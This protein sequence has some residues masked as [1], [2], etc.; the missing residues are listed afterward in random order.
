V[1][2]ARSYFEKAAQ[3]DSAFQLNL[4][5]LYRMAGDNA[6]ARASY[7]AFL[8][9]NASRPEYREVVPRVQQELSD[10]K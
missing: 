8:R 4:G 1:A 6:R 3:L 7:E 2:K 9:A 5:R 10:L